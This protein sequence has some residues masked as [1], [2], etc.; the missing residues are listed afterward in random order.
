MAVILGLPKGS[1]QEATFKMMRKAG[2]V[3]QAGSRSYSP[4]VNDPGLQCRLIRPQ[5]ISRYVELGLLDAGIT[6]Y[7]WIYENNSDV[8]EVSEMCYSKATSQSV[9]WV[10][11]VPNDSPI[12]SV[13]DLQGKRIA[14]EAVGLTRRYLAQHQVEAEVEFSWGATEVKAPELVDAIVELTETGSSLRANNLRIVD[15]ILTSTTRLI[16]NH[17]AWKNP[18]KREKIEQLAVL[19]QGALAAESRVLI[20]LNVPADRLD[21]V[22]E[23]LPSLHAPTVNRLNKRDWYAVESVVEEQV[24]RDIV[25]PL[26]NAGATGIIELPLNKVIF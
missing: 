20:K 11:A 16:A 10:L 7:D 6:G 26:R 4:S 2:F 18:A 19:L 24:V 15:T 8:H 23:L 21:T 1:L 14:T 17:K 25:P 22:T 12:Q 9:R 13:K 5:E 3:V